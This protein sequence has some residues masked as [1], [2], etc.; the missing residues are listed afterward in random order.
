[1]LIFSENRLQK[2][3]ANT[4]YIVKWFI[5]IL[6]S[7]FAPFAMYTPNAPHMSLRSNDMA[8]TFLSQLYSTSWHPSSTAYHLG[9]PSNTFFAK[10]PSECPVQFVSLPF[11]CMVCTGNPL[12]FL[13]RYLKFD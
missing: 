1:M 4:R 10:R 11:T 7:R 6:L 8:L 12:F 3:L 13:K 9:P 5:C 2:I